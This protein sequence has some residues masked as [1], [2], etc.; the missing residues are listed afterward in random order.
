MKHRR[1]IRSVSFG[2]TCHVSAIDKGAS[3]SRV[4][5]SL[6]TIL[7]DLHFII[8]AGYLRSVRAK[9][10]A[11]HNDVNVTG[12]CVSDVVEGL[13]DGSLNL[14]LRLYASCFLEVVSTTR[15]P[16]GLVASTEVRV[17]VAGCLEGSKKTFSGS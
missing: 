3:R 13:L 9:N 7:H 1:V 6:D 12:H 8:S 2:V 14:L 15:E 5:S 11:G 10:I 16:H 4:T 17:Q